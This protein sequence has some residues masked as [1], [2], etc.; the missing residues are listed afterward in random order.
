MGIPDGLIVCHLPYGPTAYFGLSDVV[1]R[2]DIERKKIGTMSEQYPHLIFDN[3]STRLGK[4]VTSVLKYLFPVPKPESRRIMTFANRDDF[5]LMRHHVY[6]KGKD[7]IELQEVGPR[8]TMRLYQL[9]LGTLDQ[10]EAENEWVLR[11]YMNTAYKR[12]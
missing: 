5:I 7:G 8:F 2:H 12:K 9:R 4:R 11:P 6:K 1:M 3:F 10:S